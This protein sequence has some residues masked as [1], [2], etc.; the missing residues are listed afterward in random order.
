MQFDDLSLAIFWVTV[1]VAAGLIMF[2]IDD[3]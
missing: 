3:Q 1:I 2:E